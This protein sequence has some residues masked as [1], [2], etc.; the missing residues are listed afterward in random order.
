MARVGFSGDLL[1]PRTYFP[2]PTVATTCFGHGLTNFGHDQFWAQTLQ[3]WERGGGGRRSAAQKQ[4]QE[5]QQQ[6]RNSEGSAEGEVPR[7]VP[8]G[9]CPEG[10]CPEGGVGP[11]KGGRPKNFSHDSPRTSHLRVRAIQTPKFKNT[12][13]IPRRDPQEREERTKIVAGEGKK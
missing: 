2:R 10:W 5:K 7:R 12:T 6:P 11:P 4:Q 3:R 1:W 9:W 8:E 13:E